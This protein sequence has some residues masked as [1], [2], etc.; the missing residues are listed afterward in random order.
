ML[1]VLTNRTVPVW[2]AGVTVGLDSDFPVQKPTQRQHGAL[3]GRQP[4]Q[5]AQ[6]DI[7]GGERGREVGPVGLLGGRDRAA[8]P[9]RGAAAT[10]RCWR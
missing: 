2:T 6:H 8:A 10:S 7:A 1:P 9:G 5:R 3:A 4:G